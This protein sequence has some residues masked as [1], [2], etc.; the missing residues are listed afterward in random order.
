[1]TPHDWART[2]AAGG[3]IGAPAVLVAAHPDDETLFAGA[4]LA[5]LSDLR[6]IMV[7]DGA[8][9]DV[10]HARSAGF[11]TRQAY[12]AARAEELTRALAIL[13]PQARLIGYD[14]PDQ[15]A[16][17]RLDEIAARLCQDLRGAAL[18]LTHPYE[19]GHPD[20]DAVA[21]AVHRAAAC[22]GPRAPAIVEFA[23]YA[24]FDGTR[25]FGRFP[26]HPD[27]PEQV[28]PLDAADRDRIERALAA[29]VSQASVFGRWRPTAEHWRAAPA[30]DFAAPPPGEACL[31]DQYGW[32]LTSARWRELASR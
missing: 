15:Q 1:M 26:P 16:V 28:R 14:V 31:Y 4:T 23:C 29:H 24:C 7:T 20:H 19:G 2:L 5:R 8:P 32:P 25:E 6:V 21:C 10:G 11:A 3:P 22:L 17:D 27:V 9:Q 13:A 12:A 18:V 30:Y